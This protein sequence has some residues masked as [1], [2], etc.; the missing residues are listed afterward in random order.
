MAYREKYNPNFG[1]FGVNVAE[2]W[3]EGD[4]IKA[5]GKSK[6]TLGLAL[7]DINNTLSVEPVSDA[8]IYHLLLS[9]DR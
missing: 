1:E 4:F 8:P 2:R 3:P 6:H 9:G 7:S 5:K